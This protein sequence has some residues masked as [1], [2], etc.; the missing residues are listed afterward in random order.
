MARTNR[1]E[2]CQH[3][4]LF[5]CPALIVISFQSS[6]ILLIPINLSPFLL[7]EA[8]KLLGSDHMETYRFRLKF[9][10]SHKG[11]IKGESG[12]L[13][14]R[15][16]NG[17]IATMKCL[18]AEKFDE[19]KI[20]TIVSGGYP[21]EEE[22]ANCACELKDVI[23]CFGAKYRMGVDVGHD[24][25]SGIFSNHIKEEFLKERK[26]RLTTALGA[27]RPSRRRA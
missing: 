1:A 11:L 19:S 12:E 2:G 14:F 20:F 13:A 22:A 6:L 21:T 10:I 8:F 16:P 5:Q 17:H 27:A 25:A 23:L 3:A 4:G 7:I 26:E 18:Q 15:L 24:K 9:H